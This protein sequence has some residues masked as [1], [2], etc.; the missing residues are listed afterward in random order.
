VAVILP[1]AV[2]LDL[3]DTILDDSGCVD[4]CWSEAIAAGVVNLP[5]LTA[6]VFQAT[7]REHAN[8]WWSDP[9]RNRRGRLDLRTATATVVNESLRKLGIEDPTSAAS[10][11]NQYRDLRQERERLHEGAI[12]TIEWFREQGVTLGLMTNGAG[13]PQRTKIDRFNLGQ[14]FGHIVI[15]GEFGAGKPHP[16]VYQSLLAAL[17]ADPNQAWAVGDNI[18]ADVRGAMKQGIHGIWIDRHNKGHIEGLA[19]D[20]TITALRDLMHWP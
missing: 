13:P 2:F 16:S 4:E 10:I 17:H 14:Y 1:R 20:R 15:E 19:P 8:W 6:D 18:E 3:D 12:E 11:A 5:G 7:L 9:D